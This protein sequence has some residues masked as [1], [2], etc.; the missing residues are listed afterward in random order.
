MPGRAASFTVRNQPVRLAL[1]LALLVTAAYLYASG[2]LSAPL[3]PAI[4]ALLFLASSWEF[5]GEWSH[6][7]DPVVGVIAIPLAVS[8]IVE[9]LKL[10]LAPDLGP[11]GYL[12]WIGQLAG[13]ATGVLAT[14]AVM[15]RG[16]STA[17]EQEL[18]RALDSLQL[19][20]REERMRLAVENERSR[21]LEVMEGV[22][23][24]V[25]LYRLPRPAGLLQL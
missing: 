1:L 13:L 24:A 23:Q 3:I 19:H 16:Q 10:M 4:T 17:V 18:Q 20:E 15:R 9:L 6:Q 2:T 21:L 22:P 25:V 8:C 7:R 5:G 11:T 14:A 12:Q